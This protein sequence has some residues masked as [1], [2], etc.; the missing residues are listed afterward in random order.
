MYNILEERSNGDL[1]IRFIKE[2][3]AVQ[4]IELRMRLASETDFLIRELEE[5]EIDAEKQRDEIRR[6][7]GDDNKFLIG[8]YELGRLIGFISVDRGQFSRNKHVASFVIGVLKDYWGKGV[9]KQLMDTFIEWSKSIGIARI[10]IQVVEDNERALA[11]YYQ[12]GFKI[13]GKKEADHYVK[14]GSY[15]NTYILAKVM[16]RE[17][18]V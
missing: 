8:A 10:E 6:T 14:D 1:T 13:E 16:K 3:D 15:L 9:S 5:V 17:L 2:E 12:Y 4:L 11:F 7:Q 18:M